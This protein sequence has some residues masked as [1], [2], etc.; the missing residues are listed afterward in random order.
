M[1]KEEDMMKLY[2]K[3]F[4][5]ARLRVRAIRLKSPS[6]PAP[7]EPPPSCSCMSSISDRVIARAWASLQRLVRSVS[8]PAVAPREFQ[9]ETLAFRAGRL[10]FFVRDRLKTARRRLRQ[11]A[12]APNVEL[13]NARLRGQIRRRDW[14]EALREASELA[15][16]ATARRDARLMEEIGLALLRLGE[17][18]KSGRLRLES[19]RISNGPPPKEWNGENL[20]DGT[21][22]L[23]MVEDGAQSLA[24]TSL[25]A[26]AMPLAKR[27]I[28]LAAPRL[29]PLVRRTFPLADVRPARE[30]DAAAYA[31]SDAV[32]T[33]AH[34]IAYFW[35][36]AKSAESSF[37]PLRADAE[38]VSE[39]RAKYRGT[40]TKP[41]VGI[42]WSSA[43]YAKDLP[44]LLEWTR[45]LRSVDA[46]FVSLQYGR[47]DADLARLRAGH[48]ANL[49][50]DASV[51]Q[52]IDMD[53]F[54]AQIASLDAVVT[55]SN[56]GA[57][58]ASALGVPCIIL[59]D[60]RFRR[61]WPV[62]SDKAAW[63]PQVQ[64]VAKKGREWKAVIDEARTRLT[65]LLV[66]GGQR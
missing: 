28:V 17:F 60:D 57:H 18:G 1:F 5:A 11:F 36:D 61:I 44:P 56:T 34:L 38:L 15:D 12:K 47:V 7:P 54:A 43:A 35:T 3:D 49:I 45:L 59:V 25:I 14:P 30:D 63:Y 62:V 48:T 52:L 46:T 64:L 16:I 32:A 31:E 6:L 8:R 19:R 41:L 2:R 53:R 23:D 39:F 29:M 24:A 40:E 65:M 4:D 9:G 37:L 21:L 51:D 50:H 27:C 20:T 13:R 42:A 22:I 33:A 26:R 58:L 66:A 10:L 55:I